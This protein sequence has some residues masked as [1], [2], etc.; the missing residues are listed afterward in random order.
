MGIEADIVD[1]DEAAQEKSPPTGKDLLTRSRCSATSAPDMTGLQRM[2]AEHGAV[3]PV[4]EERAMHS[5]AAVA[6]GNAAASG[7]RHRESRPAPPRIVGGGRCARRDREWNMSPRERMGGSAS[8]ARVGC[9][10]ISRH[11]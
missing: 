6:S 5:Q 4:G 11:T 1:G 9:S 3:G 7:S 8:S 2:D 10:T